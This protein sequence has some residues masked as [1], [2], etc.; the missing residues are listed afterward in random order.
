MNFELKPIGLVGAATEKSDALIVLVPQDFKAGKDDL[1]ALVAQT[2]KSAD[3]EAKP[4]KLL[5]LYRPMQ[6]NA[7]RV[8]IEYSASE[9]DQVEV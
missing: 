5:A 1:S 7:A 2:L 8:I 3:L 9:L 4:G 6:A